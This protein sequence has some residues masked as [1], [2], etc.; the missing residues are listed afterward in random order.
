M[1]GRQ[2]ER[3]G[4]TIALKWTLRRMGR[5]GEDGGAVSGPDA[6]DEIRKN[7]GHNGRIKTP[8]KIQ[9]GMDIRE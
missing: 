1:K 6:M 8:D 7:I 5:Q 9:G 4:N 2:K 3:A